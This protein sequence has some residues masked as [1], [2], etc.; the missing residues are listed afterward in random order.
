MRER[1]SS[2]LL[3]CFPNGY[4]GSTGPGLSQELKAPMNLSHGAQSQELHLLLPH[5]GRS[6]ILGPLFVG[7]P[8][9]LVEIRTGIEAAMTQPALACRDLDWKWS[10]QDSIST[11][12]Q[13]CCPR[14]WPNGLCHN[15]GPW[16]PVLIAN[17]LKELRDESGYR[18][19]LAQCT[20]HIGKYFGK[21]C[22]WV[23]V[24]SGWT[25]VPSAKHKI[26]G[27]KWAW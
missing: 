24:I 14:Q 12:M 6:Q 1:E 2:F 18:W 8:G 3:F 23:Q 10:S 21:Y 5:G 19:R 13:C 26:Q 17:T 20:A 16:S 9:A 11:C 25:T 7:F 15:T 4:R 27:W 22:D